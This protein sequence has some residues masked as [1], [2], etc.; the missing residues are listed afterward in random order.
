MPAQRRPPDQ[1]QHERGEHHP[2]EDRAARPDLVEELLAS[3]APNCTEAMRSTRTRHGS[4]GTGPARVARGDNR[5]SVAMTDAQH[6]R[7]A[8]ARERTYEELEA[9]FS[10][11]DAPFALVDLDAMWANAREMLGR[12]ARDADP[13]GEQVGALPAAA[14]ARSSRATRASAA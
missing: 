9:I 5:A 4:A 13:G 7:S 11:L 10:R 2:Q 3:A 12:A 6:A 14:R 8:P 1:R